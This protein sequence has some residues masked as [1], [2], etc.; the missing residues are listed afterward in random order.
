MKMEENRLSA[1]YVE[2]A[3]GAFCLKGSEVIAICHVGFGAVMCPDSFVA[4]G[5]M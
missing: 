4:L 2:M 5:S 1:I 3:I